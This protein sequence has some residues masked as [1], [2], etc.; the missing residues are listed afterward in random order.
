MQPKITTTFINNNPDTI[1]NK[2]AGKLGR[3]PSNEEA[4]QE[5]NRILLEG[6]VDRAS[7]GLLKWQRKR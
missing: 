2:L 5:V 7:K 6:Y 4:A 1:W 3:Q